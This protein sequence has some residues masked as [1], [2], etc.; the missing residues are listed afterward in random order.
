M[1][2]STFLGRQHGQA[3]GTFEAV[4]TLN[5]NSLSSRVSHNLMA[6]ERAMKRMAKVADHWI[7]STNQPCPPGPSEMSEISSSVFSATFSED[8]RGICLSIGKSSILG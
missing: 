4:V 7:Y 1:I 6:A 3:I 2:K 8:I 5:L